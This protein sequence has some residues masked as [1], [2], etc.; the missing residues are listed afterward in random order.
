MRKYLAPALLLFFVLMLDTTVLPMFVHSVWS[1]PVSLCLAISIAV[2]LGRDLGLV[3][4]LAAGLLIDILVGYPL[5]L[6]LFQYMGAGFLA[7]MIVPIPE[8]NLERLRHPERVLLVR[9]AL[10]TMGYQLLTEIAVGVYQYFNTAR[11]E[12]IYA[13]N[14]LVRIAVTIL[15]T[16]ALLYPVRLLSLGSARDREQRARPQREEQQ[17]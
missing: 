13:G 10:F 5:G 9:L 3:Y 16:L 7:G 2:V 6:R 1:V 11:Y 4:S 12:L 8:K 14:A 15:V 17:F